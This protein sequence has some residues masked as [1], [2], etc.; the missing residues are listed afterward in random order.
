MF[1]QSIFFA[2]H[3]YNLQYNA[4]PKKELYEQF[5]FSEDLPRWLGSFSLPWSLW[6]GKRRTL[7]STKN[8]GFWDFGF[9]ITN[10]F[11]ISKT[12]GIL[13]GFGW[14]LQEEETAW[15]RENILGSAVRFSKPN[16]QTDTQCACSQLGLS[17][18]HTLGTFWEYLFKKLFQTN[19]NFRYFKV[20]NQ[21]NKGSLMCE[22]KNLMCRMCLFLIFLLFGS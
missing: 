3:I 6:A 7:N 13:F 5:F 4:L 10:G 9:D 11:L 21:E 17:S 15:R 16:S 22:F 14:V 2:I 1:L 8:R 20:E 18:Q 19:L 12:F